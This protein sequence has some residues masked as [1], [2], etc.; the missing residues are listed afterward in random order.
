[1]CDIT[2]LPLVLPTF[3]FASSQK[4]KHF[5]LPNMVLCINDKPLYPFGAIEENI[6]FLCEIAREASI[7]PY[8]KKKIGTGLEQ[9]IG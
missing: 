7:T 1:M 2:N 4:K 3:P 8:Y 5:H 9:K 6:F